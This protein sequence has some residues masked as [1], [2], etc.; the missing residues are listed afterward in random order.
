M[1]RP[2]SPSSDDE[3]LRHAAE[4]IAAGLG[5]LISDGD[6][7]DVHARE[8]VPWGA[9][10][11]ADDAASYLGIGTTTLRALDIPTVRIGGRR[12]WR[13]S[14]LDAYLASLPVERQ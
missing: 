3:R 9:A 12:L 6:R 4:L 8:Q 1:P 14:D 5:E 7:P 10:L 2:W 11:G 13:R